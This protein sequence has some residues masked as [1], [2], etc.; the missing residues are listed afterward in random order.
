MKSLLAY[1]Y[2]YNPR[3]QNQLLSHHTREKMNISKLAL[4]YTLPWIW[5]FV[6]I[7]SFVNNL[8]FYIISYL[9]FFFNFQ[10]MVTVSDITANN[11]TLRKVNT[12]GGI[13]AGSH[14]S[15]ASHSHH[16]FDELEPLPLSPPAVN[17]MNEPIATNPAHMEILE[18]RRREEELRHKE[19]LFKIERYAISLFALFFLVFNAVYWVDLLYSAK[20]SER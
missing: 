6:I 4:G 3:L 16:S 20:F 9:F 7:L 1:M 15:L 11:V 10:V 19:I 18:K 13:S 8:T 5:I 17:A 12:P 14:H 2:I